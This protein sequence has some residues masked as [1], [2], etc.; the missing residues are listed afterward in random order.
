MKY[1]IKIQTGEHHHKR[2]VAF[3]VS[4]DS[5]INAYEF[6][7]KLKERDVRK[8][9]LNTRFDSWRDGQPEKNHRYHGWN[10]SDFKGRYKQCFVFKY[11]RNRVYGFLCNP[12]TNNKSYQLCVLVRH[13]LKNQA[14]TDETE[15]KIVNEIGLNLN[16]RRAVNYFIKEKL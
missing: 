15:L 11:E 7:C 9:Q 13:A 4:D 16:V 6:F 5:K 8:K 14:E 1:E 10:K 2:G 3:L 12:K